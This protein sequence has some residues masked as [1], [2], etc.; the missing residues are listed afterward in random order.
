MVSQL[1]MILYLFYCVWSM[2]GT[3]VMGIQNAELQKNKQSALT[4]C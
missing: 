2:W 3:L 1:Y 4:V